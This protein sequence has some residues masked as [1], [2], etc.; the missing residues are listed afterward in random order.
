MTLWEFACM[1][2][3]F[4]QAQPGNAAAPAMSEDRMAE[5]GI[6]GF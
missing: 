6:E 4:K 2:E 1:T 3:G 5:L